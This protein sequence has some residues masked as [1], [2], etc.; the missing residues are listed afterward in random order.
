MATLAFVFSST[1]QISNE[2]VLILVHLTSFHQRDD[3]KT[4]KF[5]L[6][7]RENWKEGESWF[8]GVLF[9]DSVGSTFTLVDSVGSTITLGGSTAACSVLLFRTIASQATRIAHRATT[10]R[11]SSAFF[12]VAGN[13]MLQYSYDLRTYHT[14]CNAVPI[15]YGW[16]T[17]MRQSG[18]RNIG[19]PTVAHPLKRGPSQSPGSPI[20][21]VPL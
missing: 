16:P 15:C 18:R 21:N 5:S 3:S 8:F 14:D 20:F 1:Y 2:S 19:W 17:L 9:T 12:E 13:A 10:G 7:Q 6:W 4:K 11:H